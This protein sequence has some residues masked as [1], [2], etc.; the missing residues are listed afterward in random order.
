M[1]NR[2]QPGTTDAIDGLGRN[3]LRNARLERGLTRNIHP[4]ATLQDA[5]HDHVTDR[6]RIDASACDGFTNDDGT[7]VRGGDV[8]QCAA[9]RSDRC[10]TCAEDHYGLFEHGSILGS[11]SRL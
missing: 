8:L 11:G 5:P 2:L 3:F 6:R 7:Q 9:E 1:D 4:G 10:T